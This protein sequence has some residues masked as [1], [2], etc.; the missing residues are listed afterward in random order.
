[1]SMRTL[2][3]NLV[4][5]ALV[6]ALALLPAL[7]QA[8]P[9]AVQRGGQEGSGVRISA[10]FS[11]TWV[12]LQS[13]WGNEGASLDPNGGHSVGA[14]EGPSLDPNGVSSPG[15]EG[16]SLDPDGLTSPGD[17]GASLDPNG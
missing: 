4:T 7:A 5:I 14:P 15:D 9:A 6:A 12:L 3:R 13:V 17:E 2:R 8:A 16:A 11:W 10:F 1:M